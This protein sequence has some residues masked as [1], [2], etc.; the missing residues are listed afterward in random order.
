MWATLLKGIIL[1]CSYGYTSLMNHSD[2]LGLSK[3]FFIEGCSEATPTMNGSLHCS[4]W[5]DRR[6]RGPCRCHFICV[7]FAYPCHQP[8]LMLL[9]TLLNHLTS[10]PGLKAQVLL[11]SPASLCVL[12]IF[13]C[14][15]QL[16]TVIFRGNKVFFCNVAQQNGYTATWRQSKK[17][18]ASPGLPVQHVYDWRVL[19]CVSPCLWSL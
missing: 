3:I 16:C 12:L 10:P 9:R 7:T 6:H 11:C 5:V 15:L 14:K 1:S 17:A 8:H 18:M 13:R 2:A 4:E 19:S